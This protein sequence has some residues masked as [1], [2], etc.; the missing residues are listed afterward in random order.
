MIKQEH[1]LSREASMRWEGSGSVKQKETRALEHL[2]HTSGGGGGGL[3]RCHADVLRCDL[4]WI[5]SP[6]CSTL[7]PFSFFVWNRFSVRM[8]P[9]ARPPPAAQPSLSLRLLLCLCAQAAGFENVVANGE[10]GCFWEL[11]QEWV[12]WMSCSCTALW[13][14][15]NDILYYDTRALVNIILALLNVFKYIYRYR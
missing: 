1:G 3:S 14:C 2:I 7:S 9:G 5:S 10:S 6:V 4:L 12:S 11:W 8:R 13:W 15:L